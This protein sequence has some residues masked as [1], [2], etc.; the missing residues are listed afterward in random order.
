M[1][2]CMTVVSQGLSGQVWKEML[3]IVETC[4]FLSAFP[5]ILC[6]CFLQKAQT[7]EN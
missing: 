6:Y 7:M 3:E 5:S 2:L 4:T 1:C